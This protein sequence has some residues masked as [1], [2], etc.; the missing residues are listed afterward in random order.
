M[1]AAIFTVETVHGV[2]QSFCLGVVASSDRNCALE[3]GKEVLQ[4]SE[5]GERRLASRENTATD[6]SQ[7]GGS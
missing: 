2:K 3:N 6:H 7:L 5:A 1:N 4:S